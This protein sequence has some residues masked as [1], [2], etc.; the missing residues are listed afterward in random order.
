MLVGRFVR[1]PMKD[2][3]MVVVQLQYLPVSDLRHRDSGPVGG[4]VSGTVQG[5][6]MPR[7]RYAND[8]VCKDQVCQEPSHQGL[9]FAAQCFDGNTYMYFTNTSIPYAVLNPKV[10]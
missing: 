5:P 9:D 8:Q 3:A 2:S 7:I 1:L 10:L 6:G 4:T